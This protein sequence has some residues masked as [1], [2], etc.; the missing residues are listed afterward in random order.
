VCGQKALLIKAVCLSI[1]LFSAFPTF[2]LDMSRK[3]IEIKVDSW[4]VLS[5]KSKRPKKT[6]RN[7]CE[8]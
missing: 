8:I 6:M 5:R 7:L 1:F 2:S 4:S 3:M